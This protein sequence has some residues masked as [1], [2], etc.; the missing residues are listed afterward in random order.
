MPSRPELADLQW[1]GR[2]ANVEGGIGS[3]PRAKGLVEVMA[4]W[5]SNVFLPLTLT[6]RAGMQGFALSLHPPLFLLTQ[7][8]RTI[9]P[10]LASDLRKPGIYFLLQTHP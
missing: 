4:R 9:L 1:L 7:P 6:A 3:N 5:R 10:F 2:G 8:M